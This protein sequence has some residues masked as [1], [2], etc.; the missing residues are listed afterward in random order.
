MTCCNFAANDDTC[1]SALCVLTVLFNGFG[2]KVKPDPV[3]TRKLADGHIII[4]EPPDLHTQAEKRTQLY[5]YS[6]LAPSTGL[7]ARVS[8]N[9]GG[10]PIPVHSAFH[11]SSPIISQNTPAP[12]PC[13]PIVQSTSSLDDFQHVLR[14]EYDLDTFDTFEFS[15]RK[16]LRLYPGDL[17]SSEP[18]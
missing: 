7:P 8:M 9:A 17:C 16:S 2:I 10:T 4:G 14:H 18:P 13:S 11:R 6:V 12:T 5:R 15:P 1:R 3:G